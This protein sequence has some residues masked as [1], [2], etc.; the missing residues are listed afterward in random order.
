MTKQFNTPQGI[1]NN[2]ERLLK[3]EDFIC[4]IKDSSHELRHTGGISIA[5]SYN[6][7]WKLLIDK[8]MNKSD[9][10]KLA[11]IASNTMTKLR[12]DEPVNLAALGRIC[13]VLNCDYGD[14]MQYI[15]EEK[16]NDE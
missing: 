1:A 9:L 14:L 2:C 13:Y 5:I 15:P 7:M 3:K 16:T 11:D 4:N 12:R 10:R 8:K 6:R